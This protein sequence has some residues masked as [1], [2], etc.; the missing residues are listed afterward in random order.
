MKQEQAIRSDQAPAAIGPYSQGA[1]AGP[2]VFTAGQV[3]VNP[4]TK[5]MPED[6]PGQARQVM[7]NLRGVLAAAGLGFEHVVKATVFMADLRDFAAFNEIYGEYFQG[8]TPPAR[9]AF[10]VAALPLGAKIEI[11]MVAYRGEQS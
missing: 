5:E 3:P 7:E 6:L 8:T 4:A 9:S 2:F 1:Q 11:E 10:Q